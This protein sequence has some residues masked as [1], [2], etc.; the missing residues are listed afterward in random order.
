MGSQ[1]VS[2]PVVI[3]VIALTLIV[4]G[5]IGWY[6]MRSQAPG[7][8]PAPPGAPGMGGAAVPMPPGPGPGR[9]PGPP[10]GPR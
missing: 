8:G 2:K 3:T 4:I 1:E 7:G 6:L 10:G 9:P 5:L